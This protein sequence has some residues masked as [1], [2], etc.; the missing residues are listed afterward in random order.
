M[1]SR[2][3]DLNEVVENISKMLGRILGEDIVLHLTF[4]PA[5][6][7]VQADATMME[8]VLMNLAVNSGMPCPGAVGWIS[9]L[10]PW[11]L[12]QSN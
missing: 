6:A 4:Y 5:P 11:S 8:Q 7:F 9:R 1:Q 12:G 10:G 3:L 2:R